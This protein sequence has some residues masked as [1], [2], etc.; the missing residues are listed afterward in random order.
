MFQFTCI[1]CRIQVK[2]GQLA[3]LANTVDPHHWSYGEFEKNIF[4]HGS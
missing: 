4:G 3:E 1:T 2:T